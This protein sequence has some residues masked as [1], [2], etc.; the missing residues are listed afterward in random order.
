VKTSCDAFVYTDLDGSIP[1]WEA[2]IGGHKSVKKILIDKGADIF[3]ADAGHLACSAV[4]KNSIEL[5]KELKEL[6]VDVTKPGMSGMTALHKAVSDGNVEMVKFLLDVGAEVDMQDDYGWTPRG[7]AEHQGHEEIKNI[8]QNIKEN[9]QIAPVSPIPEDGMPNVSSIGR[10]Q[11]APV[12]PAA[13]GS[14]D[15]MLQPPNQEELP[16]L[17]SHRRRRANTFHNSIF[18]MIS[19]ANYGK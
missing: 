12:M 7:L 4:D 16:W 2:M 13:R 11:S 14:L 18:G 8:F 10:F 19:A 1:L 5:L 15:N 6:G 3:C 17:D 9:K